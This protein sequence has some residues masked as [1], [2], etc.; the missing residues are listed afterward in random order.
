MVKK[1]GS[2]DNSFGV[3]SV[4]LG[5]LSILSLSFGGVIMGIIGLAFS[6]Q[7]KKRNKNNWSKAGLILNIIGI[8]LGIIA[9]IFLVN[10]ASDYLSQLQQLQG[11]Y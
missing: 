3:A 11:G 8:I 5:V 10:F 9:V 4:I 6:F 2:S 1:E 7:Q